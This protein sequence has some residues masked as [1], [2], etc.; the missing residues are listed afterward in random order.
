MK[1][2]FSI[3]TRTEVNFVNYLLSPHTAG[4]KG[5]FATTSALDVLSLS[6]LFYQP[7][8]VLSNLLMRILELIEKM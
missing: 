1:E 6:L 4:D 7:A 2:S 5:K 8:R 3:T